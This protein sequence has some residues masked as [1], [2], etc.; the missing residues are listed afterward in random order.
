M[1]DSRFVRNTITMVLGASLAQII[2]ILVTPIL[3]RLY[4]PEEFGVLALFIALTSILGSI[5]SGRY[6]LA[7]ILPED[8]VDAINVAALCLLLASMFSFLLLIPVFVFNSQITNLLGSDEIGNWLYLVPFVV[9]VIALNNVLNYL[10]TRKTLYKDVSKTKVYKSIVMSALQLLLGF[11]K[12]GSIGLVVGNFVSLIFSNVRLIMNVF[13]FYEIKNGLGVSG[14]REVSVRYSSFPRYMMPAT[15]FNTSSSKVLEFGLPVIYSLSTLGFYFIVQRILATPASFIG[16]AV[17]QVFFQNLS[18]LVKDQERFRA[19]FWKVLGT[20]AVISI[21]MFSTLY[22]II[23]DLFVLV[24]GDGWQIAG[25]MAR[26]IIPLFAIQFVVSPL[27]SVN[28]VLENTGIVLLWQIL[29]FISYVL[30][31]FNAYVSSVP[32]MEL[33]EHVSVIISLC[34]AFYLIVIV[35]VV[36]RG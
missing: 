25:E 26:V 24:F 33:L 20:L 13:N 10:N 16:G 19:K 18:V 12:A 32:F 17:A 6:E 22:L 5:A 29:L 28:Q 8:D 9:L 3:T 15:F 30:I 34:Y 27:T 35:V 2:P 23:V 14:V 21:V 4:T 11:M 7:I 31:V 36:E 1:F